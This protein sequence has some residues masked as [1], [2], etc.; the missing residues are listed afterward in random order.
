[1]GKVGT[2]K[3][4]NETLKRM[5][6]NYEIWFFRKFGAPINLFYILSDDTDTFRRDMVFPNPY[7]VNSDCLIRSTTKLA[8]EIQVAAS[9]INQKPEMLLTSYA[10]YK[11]CK[12]IITARRNRA[13]SSSMGICVFI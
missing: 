12:K 6:R 2:T 8:Q 4:L 5:R 3:F 9:H 1:M 10:I 13:Y 7:R 11:F